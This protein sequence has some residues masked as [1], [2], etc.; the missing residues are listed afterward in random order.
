MITRTGR[1]RGKVPVT[2]TPDGSEYRQWS[3]TTAKPKPR[4]FA[5]I[6]AV[7]VTTS[8]EA[9]LGSMIQYPFTK[10]TNNLVFE[11]HEGTPFTGIPK[12]F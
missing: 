8:T 9:Q 12:Q 1:Y 6:V 2:G 7:Q 10:T 5:G 11:F 3:Y 4:D